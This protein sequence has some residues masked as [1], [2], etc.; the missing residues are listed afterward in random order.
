MSKAPDPEDPPVNYGTRP[1][2]ISPSPVW[3]KTGTVAKP[4]DFSN[5]FPRNSEDV[6]G[7]PGFPTGGLY[8][9]YTGLEGGYGNAGAMSDWATNYFQNAATTPYQ[10]E[11]DLY[12]NLG[13]RANYMSVPEADVYQGYKSMMGQGYSPEELQRMRQANADT[14]RSALQGG[15]DSARAN[16]LRTGNTAGVPGAIARMMGTQGE[17]VAGGEQDILARDA[18]LKRQQTEKALQGLTGSAGLEASRY[19]QATQLQNA[20]SQATT[21]RM[22]GAAQ[23]LLPY[24]QL[25]AA[26]GQFGTQGLQGLY[27]TSMGQ[28]QALYNAIAQLLGTKGEE[29]TEMGQTN[30]F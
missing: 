10:F 3:G 21:G 19:A 17:L 14:T 26:L 13:N 2:D 12:N 8:G 29:Y 24:A 18:A 9:T 27:N 11:V 25:Q 22:Q 16:M 6:W 28:D 20:L 5:Q 1:V 23:S 7:E 15:V 4:G 30:I